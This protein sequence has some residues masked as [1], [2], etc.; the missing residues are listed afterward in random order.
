MDDF[1]NENSDGQTEG[2]KLRAQFEA[3]LKK[4]KEL[5]AQLDKL[6][7]QVR[8][9]SVKDL[10]AEAKANLK[11]VK[12]YTGE[13]TKEAVEAW[14]KGDGDIFA[15]APE[16]KAEQGQ[17]GSVTPETNG[18]FPAG[19][20][21]EMVQAAQAASQM[22]PTPNSTEGLSDLASK[23]GRSTMTAETDQADLKR[24][25]EGIQT[26]ARAAYQERGY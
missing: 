13:A 11:G 20:T 9:S 25:W 7:A 1:Q 19:F 22:Q 5:Q 14:L 18:Q 15:T 2:G 26:Q 3:E 6:S 10:F 4:N 12:F 17:E 24:L 16:V 8:S 21:S 23:V